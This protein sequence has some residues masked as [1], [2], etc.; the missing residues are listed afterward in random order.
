MNR[1]FTSSLAEAITMRN[2][3]TRMAVLLA[4]ISVKIS[5]TNW[6]EVNTN[7]FRQTMNILLRIAKAYGTGHYRSLPWK[8]M[9][10]LLAALIYF[11]NPF[12]VV[13]DIIPVL[14]LSDDFAVVMWVYHSVAGEV[15]RFLAWEKA[16]PD[17]A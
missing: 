5:Q 15:E 17:A 10:T 7:T 13:P 12:D 2:K 9:A 16:Q 8:A 3:H 4:K 1:F 6:K 11:L 14:G